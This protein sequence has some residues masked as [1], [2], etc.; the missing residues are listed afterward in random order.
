MVVITTNDHSWRGTTLRTIKIAALLLSLI[1]TSMLS[2]Q[3]HRPFK[4]AGKRLANRYHIAQIVSHCLVRG[5]IAIEKSDHG[6]EDIAQEFSQA[7][8]IVT[9]AGIMKDL[10]GKFHGKKLI[11]RNALALI[12]SKLLN[13]FGHES[14]PEAKSSFRDVTHGHWARAAIEQMV[15]LGIMRGYN[16]KFHG[17]KLLNR[18]QMSVVFAK[19]AEL[20]KLEKTEPTIK[21]TDVPKGHWA[22]E[23]IQDC[24]RWGLL[25]VSDRVT[26]R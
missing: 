7:V 3:G 12:L 15:E 24:C 4:F 20:L 14:N 16:G 13:K 23:A 8:S 21:Y 11:N 26:V 10:D 9:K 6:L 5:K 17:K 1:F 22:Y 18:Y 19:V 25:K 2:A